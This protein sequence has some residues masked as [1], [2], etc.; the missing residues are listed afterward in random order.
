MGQNLTRKSLVLAKSETTYGTDAAPTAGT[1]AM[2]LFGDGNV[3]QVDQKIIDKQILRA[4]LTPNKNL[5]GRAL[6]NISMGTVLMSRNTTASNGQ[7]WFAPLLKACALAEASGATAGSSSSTV[8]TPK[9][10]AFTSA[11]IWEYADGLR[12]QATGC[13]GSFKL[14][15]KAGESPDLGFTMKGL[16][17]SGGISEVTFPS[18]TYP[19]DTKVMVESEGLSIGSF[20]SAAGLVVRSLSL[21]W[22]NNVVERADANSAKGLKGLYITGRTP[23]LQIV[24]EVEDE[25]SPDEPNDFWSIMAAATTSNNITWNHATGTQSV[26]AFSV[27]G[28]QLTNIQYGDDS[29]MRTYTLDYAL[30]SS[31]DEGEFSMAFK[32]KAV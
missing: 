2:L 1:D 5:V 32:E 15:M 24:I 16:F 26:I 29:G 21:D 10:S 17:P 13:Y 22:A 4:S 8:Y 3:F 31:T 30:Q 19:T 7:P 23:K 18:A 11:T 27:N 25:F 9:S 14:D 20:N 6:W 12:M 28:P